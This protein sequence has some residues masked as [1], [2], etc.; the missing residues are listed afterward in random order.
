MFSIED[1]YKNHIL[2][3]VDENRFKCSNVLEISVSISSKPLTEKNKKIY[4]CRSEQREEL[5]KLDIAINFLRV[6]VNYEK[7]VNYYGELKFPLYKLKWF[8]KNKAN[9][10]YSNIESRRVNKRKSNTT[11]KNY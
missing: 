7:F 6:K 9:K 10:Y 3:N 5:S 1:I 2:K 8:V 11:T 4:Y